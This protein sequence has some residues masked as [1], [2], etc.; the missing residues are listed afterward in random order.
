MAISLN[1]TL[2]IK[3]SIGDF[4]PSDFSMGI[5]DA[6]LNQIEHALNKDFVVPNAYHKIDSI[7]GDKN[8]IFITLGIYTDAT[9]NKKWLTTKTYSFVPDVSDVTDNFIKQGYEY[10]KTLDEF[11]DAVDC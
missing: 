9:N 5:L 3:Y 6:Q 1:Y 10:L 4:S 7:G 8:Q 11:A 2:K